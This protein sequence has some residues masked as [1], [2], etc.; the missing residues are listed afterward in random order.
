MKTPIVLTIAGSDPSGGAGIQSD[1]RAIESLGGHALSAI[2]ALTSQNSLGVQ[3]VSL[4]SASVLASQLNVLLEDTRPDAVKIGM[5]GGA[6]QVETVARILS[7]YD[8]RNVVL[9]PVL[10][11]TGGA[12][13]LDEAGRTALVQMLLPLCAVVTPNLD[14]AQILTGIAIRATADAVRAGNALLALGVRAALITGGHFAGEP[15]DILVTPHGAQILN[16]KRVDTPHTHGTGCLFSSA[17][18]AYLG[19]GL[20]LGQAAARAKS[21][22]VRALNNPV[23]IGQG[24]GYP[25]PLNIQNRDETTHAERLKKIGGVYVLTDSDLRPNRSPQEIVAAALQGGSRVVQLRDKHRAMPELIELAR[26]LRRMAHAT[27]ALLI[28]NDRVDV[29]LAS[30]ADGVHLGPDDMS[31]ADARRL[32]GPDK[33]V[34]VSVSSVEEAAPLAP[35]ASYLGVGAIYGS[36]TKG[37]AGAPVGTQRIWEIANAFPHLPIVAIGGIDLSNIAEVARTGAH[38]A[39]VISAV[40][41]ADDMERAT[42][43]LVDAFDQQFQPFPASREG[44]R[45]APG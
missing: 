28:V 42:Q 9:D 31:V 15:T 1:L 43:I 34:G 33:I 44:W 39:A 32:L 17:L 35:H 22:V 27:N 26:E 13:L 40:V 12:P 19:M 38:A 30:D 10:A 7:Q 24:R 6:E 3:S 16:G 25:S 20:E 41:C 23:V 4:T 2:T 21:A 18:A 36:T 11:S 37:D 8:L 45:E 14:E 29:A 5:L